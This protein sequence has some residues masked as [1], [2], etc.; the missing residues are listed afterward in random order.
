MHLILE[1][2]ELFTHGRRSETFKL[3]LELGFSRGMK[4]EL[5]AEATVSAGSVV[6]SVFFFDKSL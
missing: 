5:F 4:Y 2:S 6:A 1:I 3:K